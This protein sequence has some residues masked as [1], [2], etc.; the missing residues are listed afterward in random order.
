[1]VFREAFLDDQDRTLGGAEIGDFVV[2]QRVGDVE[3][4]DGDIRIAEHVGEADLLEPADHRIVEPAEADDPDIVV[5]AGKNLVELV[6][7]D[8]VDR[9]GEAFLDF[10]LLLLVGRRG[11]GDTPEVEG[12]L[13][14]LVVGRERAGLVVL[15]REAAGDVA[16]ADAELHHDRRVRGLGQLEPLLDQL[17]HPRVVG[18]GVHQPGRALHGEG[19]G[20]LLDDAR[21]LAVILAENDQRAADD[22][23]GRDVRQRIGRDIGA[24]RRLPG[25]R[26]PDRVVDRG[27]EHRRRGGLVG[28]DLGM[29]AELGHQP[30]GIGGQNIHQ[31]GDRRALVAADIAHARL[32][33]GLGDGENALALEI[34][35]IAPAQ[36]LDFLSEAPFHA[37][38]PIA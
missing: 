8:E 11:Q 10:F 2:D 12:R 38:S 4:E 1:M 14:Q 15:G 19:V 18:A 13:L 22:A 37:A 20:A 34:L 33:Q 28:A 7:A 24:D 32:Q 3:A 35:A 9:R 29:D 25:D 30:L 17:D 16:G 23:G 6:L 21:A 27:R 26:A 5:L 31:M 36:K